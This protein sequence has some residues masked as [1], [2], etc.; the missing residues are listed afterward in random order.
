MTTHRIRAEM[1]VDRPIDEVFAFFAR[2]ENLGRITPRHL[3]FE[4]R[5]DDTRMRDGLEIEYRIRPLLGIPMTW[6]SRSR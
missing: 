3:G 2:P 6:R 4:L 5:T 1:L